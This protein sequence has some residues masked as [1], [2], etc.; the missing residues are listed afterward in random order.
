MELGGFAGRINFRGN[1]VV[2]TGLNLFTRWLTGEWG[3]GQQNGSLWPGQWDVAD[4][5]FEW[6]DIDARLNNGVMRDSAVYCSNPFRGV[7]TIRGN[8]IRTRVPA[9]NSIPITC[10]IDARLNNGVMRDSAVYC[11]NPFRGVGTIR[12]NTIRT[13][14]PAAN[15][16]PITCYHLYMYRKEYKELWDQQTNANKGEF[17]IESNRFEGFA[18]AIGVQN[19]VPNAEIS[20]NIL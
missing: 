14:V 3:L 6:D 13:R 20:C 7:G 17:L 1:T 19:A 9:A 8:T 15:S 4:N 12:G 18:H 11:S 5:H 2:N 16:I 10:D